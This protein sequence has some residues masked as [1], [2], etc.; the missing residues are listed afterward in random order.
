MPKRTL[1]VAWAALTAAALLAAAGVVGCPSLSALECQ[2]AS[3]ADGGAAGG[4]GGGVRGIACG[5]GSSCA[6]PGQECCLAAQG[7]A[8]CVVAQSCNGGSDIFCDDPSQCA[9]APCF[10]CN[11]GG[12]FQGTSC[13]Y[14]EDIVQNYK[15]TSASDV[16]RLCHATSQCDAGTT[17]KPFPFSL[18]LPGG[19]GGSWFFAC[20]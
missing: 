4:D 11:A 5:A 12:T 20:Q 6:P 19:D 3:C 14:Q 7:A 16:Y 9:G 18:P 10:L 17:C 1:A 2:G 8:S 13:R 15:C